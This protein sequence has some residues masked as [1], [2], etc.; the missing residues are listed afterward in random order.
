MG[1]LGA[2]IKSCRHEFHELTRILGKEDQWQ[3]NADKR[4]AIGKDWT[5]FA[6]LDAIIDSMAQPM[7]T[8]DETR[9][10]RCLLALEAARFETA[11]LRLP[12]I[13]RAHYRVAKRH[14]RPFRQLH[15]GGAS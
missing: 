10:G 4:I 12:E 13:I 14:Y 15:S 11:V 6:R 7:V 2:G 3:T 1:R 8:R 9:C 5:Y